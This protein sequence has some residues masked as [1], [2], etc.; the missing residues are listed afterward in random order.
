[1]TMN[2]RFARL[3]ATREAAPIQAQP[4]SDDILRLIDTIL[5]FARTLD[6][7]V[8]EIPHLADVAYDQ[9]DYDVAEPNARSVFYVM[10]VIFMTFHFRDDAFDEFQAVLAD[11]LHN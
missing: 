6:V 8:S 5:F 4:S 3:F 9:L 10:R 1:M 11:K 7:H 2:E